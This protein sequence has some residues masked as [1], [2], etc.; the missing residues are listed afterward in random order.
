[1]STVSK[2]YISRDTI[3]DIFLF[4]VTLSKPGTVPTNQ[5]YLVTLSLQLGFL[6]IL[7]YS[8]CTMQLE[9]VDTDLAYT[10]EREV[11]PLILDLK[12]CV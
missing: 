12:L 1:M 9:D 8:L 4:G 6:C 2:L 10:I 3:S 5:G 7:L 11:F